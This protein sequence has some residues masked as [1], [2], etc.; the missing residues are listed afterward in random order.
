MMGIIEMIGISK[1]YAQPGDSPIKVLKDITLSIDKADLAA[2]MGPSGSG[3]TT[4][5]NIMGFLLKPSYGKYLFEGKDYS[6]YAP[7]KILNE[8]RKKMGFVFQF[9]HLL[10]TLNVIRN[11]ELSAIIAGA[12]KS[13]R[14]K[15]AKE[16][17]EYVGLRGKA[18]SRV[19]NLSRGEMQRVAIARALINDPL[20]ILADE[21]TASVDSENRENIMDLIERTNKEKETTIILTTHDEYVARRCREVFYLGNGSLT[22]K[23]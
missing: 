15:K 17:I 20:L 19:Y 3:K 2:I 5:L 21:P 7:E 1:E 23:R 12:K 6:G 16:L 10:P 4:L 8:N 11:V 9:F 22:G 18:K 14:E 13:E